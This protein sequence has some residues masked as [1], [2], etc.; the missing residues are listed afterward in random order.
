MPNQYIDTKVY[1][2]QIRVNAQGLCDSYRRCTRRG[3]KAIL[4]HKG[5]CKCN[6]YYILCKFLLLLIIVQVWKVNT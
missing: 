4:L 2:C 1:V 3:L 5:Y 6:F